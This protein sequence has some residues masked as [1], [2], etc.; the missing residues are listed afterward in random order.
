MTFVLGVVLFALGIGISIALHEFGHLLTAKAFGMKAT[1]YFV[2]FGPKIFSFRKGETE[3]G[4]KAIPAG[5]FVQIVGMTALEEVDPADEP[6]AFYNKPVWQRV[7]VLAAGSITHFIIGILVLFLMAVSI[8]LPNLGNKPVVGEISACVPATPTQKGCAPGD[9]AP[10]RQ[11]GL[12]PG[13]EILAVGGR[14]TATYEDVLR[15]TREMAGPT[16]FRIRRDGQEQTLTVD[17]ARVQRAPLDPKPGETQLVSVGAVGLSNS[18]MLQH[19]VLE[20]VPATLSLT[21]DMFANTWEGIKKLPE[22]VPAVWRAIMGENDPQRPV[23]V[24][25]ASV[26]GGDAVERGLW[27]LF[28]MLLAGLNFFVGV[29]NLLPL[30]PMDGGHIAVNVYG[31][32]RDWV[33]RMRGLPAG[34]PVD[35]TK[36]LPI[37]YVLML[38]GGAMMLLT[39]TADIVNPIRLPQ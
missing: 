34:G 1:R 5:G 38:L 33:R 4:L 20:A 32:V 30:L 37:T 39:V 27:E 9:P 22:K 6:R 28:L 12:K 10:A 18:R 17:V 26:I 31:R 23:S 14:A 15:T 8:G 16:P 29:F 2:G 19:G 21:G 7:V 24:V 13:D 3:Y 11:A 36:L 35:Y 25:G